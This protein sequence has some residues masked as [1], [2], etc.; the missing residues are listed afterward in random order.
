MAVQLRQRPPQQPEHLQR[1]RQAVHRRPRRLGC[2]GRGV[3]ARDDGRPART[4]DVRLRAAR[5]P[6][7]VRREVTAM[8]QDRVP[9]LRADE[10][11]TPTFEEIP[12]SAEATAY[13]GVQDD[14]D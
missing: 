2:L 12:V 6:G 13:M 1:R 3:P 10:W 7:L 9:T 5:G 11:E 8:D 4:G 14:W